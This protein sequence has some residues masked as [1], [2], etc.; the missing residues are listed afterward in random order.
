[1]ARAGIKRIILGA[2]EGLAVNNGATFSAAIAALAVHDAE[3]LLKCAD[4]S[5]SLTLCGSC[6][7]LIS[8]PRELYTEK[9]I[10]ALD[11]MRETGTLCDG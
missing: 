10:C 6:V 4:L 3:T 1:M 5:L 11:K 8:L 7:P 2:K 9:R